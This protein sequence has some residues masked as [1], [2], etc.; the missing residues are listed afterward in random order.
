MNGEN[1]FF[2]SACGSKAHEAF[3]CQFSPDH[4]V[5]SAELSLH[6]LGLISRSTEVIL[7]DLSVL[8]LP[9]NTS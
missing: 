9:G 5:I 6:S 7:T 4:S 8:V 2:S 3:S 1:A